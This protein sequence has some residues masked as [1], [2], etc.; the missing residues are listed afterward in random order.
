MLK[1]AEA[2]LVKSSVRH[3]QTNGPKVKWLYGRERSRWGKK[4]TKQKQNKQKIKRKEKG[5]NQVNFFL[6]L[7]IKI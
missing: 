6:I 1:N 7:E 2:A 3:I 4:K 5:E